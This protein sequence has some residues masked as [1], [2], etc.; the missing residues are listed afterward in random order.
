MLVACSSAAAPTAQQQSPT[1]PSPTIRTA[2]PT[3]GS[4][5]LVRIAPGDYV[6]TVAT[7]AACLDIPAELRTRTYAATLKASTTRP[8]MQFLV[9]VSG[10]SL[11]T[12]FG[13]ALDVAGSDVGFT[14]DGPAFRERF[15]SFTYLEISGRAPTGV[16]ATA[17]GRSISIPFSGSVE[18]C[19]LKSEMR[20][21]ANCS[22][23][24]PDQKIAASQC[25]ANSHRL[26]LTPR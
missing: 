10:G 7:D 25:L 24:A 12:P 14:I 19:I 16:A 17:T 22:N 20:A 11:A 15:P 2:A 6:L 23:T 21:D 26:I 8:N 13:F 1:D 5:A 9:D 4:S 18:Y 3:A